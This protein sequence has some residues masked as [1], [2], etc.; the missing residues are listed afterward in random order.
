VKVVL[1]VR[2]AE[3]R[4]TEARTDTRSPGRKRCAGTKLAPVPV[5]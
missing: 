5:E 1:A 3:P 4:P 2:V